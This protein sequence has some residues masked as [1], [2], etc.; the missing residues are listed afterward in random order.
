MS[1]HK[2][3]VCSLV[4]AF[5]L[6]L[7]VVSPVLYADARDQATQF[8]F[9]HP[10]RVPGKILPA[11]TYWFALLNRS[12]DQ[13]TV[14]IYNADRRQLIAVVNTFSL[15]RVAPSSHTIITVTEPAGPSEP[16]TVL[17]WFY[18]GETV[19]HQFVYAASGDPRL[20]NGPQLTLELDHN[21]AV[22]QRF[23]SRNTLGN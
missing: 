23:G 2:M 19:G 17:A 9:S 22:S 6:A 14:A 16:A 15:E 11:G 8:T 10:V 7:A 4:A 21:G 5:V 13:Q 3:L 1:T 20:S 18:P 12:S